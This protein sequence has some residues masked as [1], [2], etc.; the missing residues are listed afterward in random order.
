MVQFYPDA[1]EPAKTIDQS[2]KDSQEHGLVE[3]ATLPKGDQADFP[4]S[5]DKAGPKSKCPR[6]KVIGDPD[7]VAVEWLDFV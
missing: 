1:G 2:E 3:M 6:F 7:S 4:T 5:G